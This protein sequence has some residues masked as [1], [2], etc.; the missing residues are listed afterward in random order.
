MPRARLEIGLSKEQILWDTLIWS[1]DLRVGA[2]ASYSN[3]VLQA[4]TE[5]VQVRK[6]GP[7]STL[8]LSE[9]ELAVRNFHDGVRTTL[10]RNGCLVTTNRFLGSSWQSIDVSMNDMQFVLRGEDMLFVLRP[11]QRPCPN[12]GGSRTSFELEGIAVVEHLRL[13]MDS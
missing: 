9:V 5:Y 8:G 13:S 4:W 11:T 7:A 3:D 6:E 1:N 12:C 2:P 10:A